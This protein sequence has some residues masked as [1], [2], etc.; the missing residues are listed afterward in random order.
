MNSVATVL[1]SAAAFPPRGLWSLAWSRLT[2][3]RV[4]LVSLAV[5]TIYVL[6]L[7]ASAA[8]LIAVTPLI[9]PLAARI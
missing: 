5:V 8:G 1:S 2:R 4:G 6:V 9:T 7:C 3:D